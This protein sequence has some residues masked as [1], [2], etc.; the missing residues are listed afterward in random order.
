MHYN[1]MSKQLHKDATTLT[2]A[3][4]H[5]FPWLHGLEDLMAIVKRSFSGEADKDR[6]AA[7]ACQFSSEN[8][9]VIDLP[10][11]LSSWAFDDPDNIS[12]WLDENLRLVAWA[13]LQTPFWSIDYVFDPGADP[14]LPNK[15]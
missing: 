9:H 12:L 14:S 2:I 5:H 3:A 11:R 4:V 6:M 7:L 15:S 10:Y 1:A 8:L 13:A